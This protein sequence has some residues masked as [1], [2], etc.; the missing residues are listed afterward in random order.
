MTAAFILGQDVNLALELGVGMNG[1]GLGQNL[2]AL[3]VGTLN[4]A[5]QNADVVASLGEVQQLAEHLDAGN[6][7]LAG[8]VSQTDDLNFLAHLQNATLHT[9]SSNGAAAG[10]GEHVLNG[11][12]EGL[13][14]LALGSGDILVHSV[15]ELQNALVLGSVGIGRGALQ[16]SQGGTLDDGGVVAGELV[17]VEQVADLHLNQ[18]QQLGVVHLVALV[19][20]HDDIGHAHLTGQ[21][22]VLT[23]LRHGA[24][25]SGHNQ[26]GAVHLSST[27]NHVLHVVSVAGAVHMSV[28]ALVGLILNVSGVDGDA[29]LALLGSLIDVGIV[30][31]LSV[32]LH[33]Q[34]LGDSGGQSGLTVVNVADGANV[35]VRFCSFEFFLCHWD[36]L[37]LFARKD[38]PAL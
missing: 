16:G 36:F 10:D 33:G 7:G 12:Q 26:D 24:V 4:A 29:A 6:D 9:A 1:A 27:G 21:Q 19:H 15:H 25:S 3:D 2:A 11:H 17:L 37:L 30:H 28:V 5:Q 23:G 31:E 13:V 35:N 18:L 38:I 14:S 22:D 8:L 34:D 20:E 32:A